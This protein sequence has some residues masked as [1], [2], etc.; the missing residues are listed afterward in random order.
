VVQG[1]RAKRV[2][3]ELGLEDDEYVEVL[4]GLEPG[5][6]VVSSGQAGLK[7]NGLIERVDETGR[8][9][10]ASASVEGPEVSAAAEPEGSPGGA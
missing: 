9:V 1:D 4:E 10:E 7:D 2:R 6:E 5:D 3:L 8:P